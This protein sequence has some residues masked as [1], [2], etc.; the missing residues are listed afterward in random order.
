MDE[1][2]DLLCSDAT[3][4]AA[5]MDVLQ[6][7]KLIAAGRTPQV[8]PPPWPASATSLIVEVGRA[9][10]TD[11][12]AREVA[13]RRLAETGIPALVAALW[14]AQGLLWRS[15]V[16]DDTNNANQ[17]SFMSFQAATQ[18]CIFDCCQ[19][20]CLACSAPLFPRVSLRTM[21]QKFSRA[22]GP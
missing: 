13:V 14:F 20:C 17:H 2:L 22:G 6:I 18:V 5:A 11:S 8:P 16:P 4:A 21:R 10:Q 15:L 7:E 3:N 1:A 19:R 12:T 9:V